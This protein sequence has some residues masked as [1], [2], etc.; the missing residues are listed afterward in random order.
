[1]NPVYYF[2]Y[3]FFKTMARVFY[4]YHVVHPERLIEKG[5]AIVAANHAS[6]LDPP[7]VGVAFCEPIYYLARKSL[8]RTR[9][10]DWLYQNWNSIPVD[11]DRPDMTSLKTIIRLLREGNRV[12]IFPEGSRSWDGSLG[13]G[14]PG[15]GLLV[16]KSRAP[17]IP[18]RIFGA[19]EALPRGARFPRRSRI[20]IVVGEP[21]VFGPEDLGDGDR[22]S[23]QRISDRIM[24]AIGE[25]SL[26]C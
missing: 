16:A 1:M 4:R 6:F 10:F 18:V 25:L 22:G 7:M 21:I 2:G 19:G 12:L 5:P 13:K 20:T 26:G 11:Q 24:E 15:V 8:F 17:V 14:M 9:F 23:Y 3:T